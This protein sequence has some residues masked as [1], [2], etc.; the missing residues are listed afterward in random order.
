MFVSK[1]HFMRGI[2]VLSVMYICSVLYAYT[3]VDNGQWMLRPISCPTMY[4]N[5]CTRWQCVTENGACVPMEPSKYDNTTECFKCP[6]NSVRAAYLSK[7][8]Y[9]D[10]PSNTWRNYTSMHC[11]DMEVLLFV[12]TFVVIVGGWLIPGEDSFAPAIPDD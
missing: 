9:F 4:V 1:S 8:I 6:L 2:T 7:C 3:T 12:C 5:N 11:R 10:L